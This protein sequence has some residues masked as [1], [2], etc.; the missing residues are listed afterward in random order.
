MIAIGNFLFT[1]RNGLF[2]IFYAL[3]FFK[4]P[5]I[6][7]D[8]RI[9]AS[10]GILVALIGQLLRVVT[11]GLEYIRRGG[12]KRKVYADTLVQGG[13]F[14]HCRNPLYVG[15]YLILLGVGF[16]ANS[17]LFMAVAVPF[18]TFAYWAIIS[19]EENFLRNKFGE[20]FERYCE[21]VNRLT[22]NFSGFKQTVAGMQFNWRR[23][24]VKEY[25]SAYIWMAAVPLAMLKNLWFSEQYEKNQ[26]L[27]WCMWSA[28]M[29]VTL[30]YALARYLKKSGLLTA[31]LKAAG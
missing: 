28:F 27:A 3:L 2:P 30:A 16:A 22:P 14:A 19:A 10:I 17:L 7:P 29:V 24:I 8:Y 12:L 11:I 6:L 23:V 1:Y 25:G 21:S 9:A 20:E 31:E 13:V 5:P 18:F 26:P 4:S 15:N